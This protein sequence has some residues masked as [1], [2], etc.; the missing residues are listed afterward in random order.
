MYEDLSHLRP[1]EEM[2]LA[3]SQHRQEFMTTSGKAARKRIVEK[4]L[5]EERIPLA[6]LN[7][8]VL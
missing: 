7:Q 8:D 6:I 1:S 4:A 3:T 5:M 2:L